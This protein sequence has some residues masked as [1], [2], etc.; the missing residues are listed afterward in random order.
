MDYCLATHR[1]KF[2]VP[3]IG[4]YPLIQPHIPNIGFVEQKQPWVLAAEFYDSMLVK[5]VSTGGIKHLLYI[6]AVN[7]KL[8]I[9][10]TK[11]EPIIEGLNSAHVQFMI[12]DNACTDTINLTSTR[13]GN[14]RI[15]TPPDHCERTMAVPAASDLNSV[16]FSYSVVGYLYLSVIAWRVYLVSSSREM[17]HIH[18]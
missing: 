7:S 4:K 2:R 5:R 1:K 11:N 15:T 13:R 9:Y 3:D 10:G 16:E 18:V 12:R 14:E 6:P 17:L 8:S